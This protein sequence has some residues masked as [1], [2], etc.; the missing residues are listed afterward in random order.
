MVKM[1]DGEVLARIMYDAAPANGRG[2][3]DE[4]SPSVRNVQLARANAVLAAGWH[5]PE[6]GVL[7]E[8]RRHAAREASMAEVSADQY[9]EANNEARMDA[10]SGV[11]RAYRDI[12]E[13][14]DQL[15]PELRPVE[16]A[17]PV[18]TQGQTVRDPVDLALVAALTSLQDYQHERNGSEE[19]YFRTVAI[20]SLYEGLSQLASLTTRA[21]QCTRYALVELPEPDNTMG[22]GERFYGGADPRFYV[23]TDDI[24]GA[25]FGR[26]G[27]EYGNPSEVRSLAAAF[28]GAAA[29]GERICAARASTSNDPSPA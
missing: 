17:V 14:I 10:E 6:R 29:A 3:F 27:Q 18:D 13:L 25:V 2:S 1:T 19:A 4:A 20:R 22:D 11:A 9:A 7:A 23:Q 5:P 21:R 8:L 28:L 12:V 26:E 16:S 24:T 15:V